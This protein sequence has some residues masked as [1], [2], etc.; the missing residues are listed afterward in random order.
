MCSD[1]TE[2]V[3]P[4]EQIHMSTQSIALTPQSFFEPFPIDIL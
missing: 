1:I 4:F 3:H 2:L